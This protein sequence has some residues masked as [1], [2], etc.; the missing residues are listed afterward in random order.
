MFSRVKWLLEGQK[1]LIFL[2]ELFMGLLCTVY[3]WM[4]VRFQMEC[5]ILEQGFIVLD[6]KIFRYRILLLKI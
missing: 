2:K 5:L 6:V 3:H 1:L 4:T